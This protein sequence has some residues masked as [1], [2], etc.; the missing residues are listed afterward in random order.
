MFALHET[1]R[2]GLCRLGFFTLCVL[3]ACAIVTASTWVNSASRHA[4]LEREL[5]A[6]LG[7]SV[8]VARVQLTRPNAARYE[9]LEIVDPETRRMIARAASLQISRH[10]AMTVIIAV[11]PEVDAAQLDV[12][13]GL[14]SRELKLGKQGESVRW[15]A[16]KLTLQ[17]ADGGQRVLDDVR[18][19]FDF[20][21]T[22]AQ[23]AGIFRVASRRSDDEV[24]LR[25]VRHRDQT[26][27]NTEF[28][29]K[30]SQAMLPCA[31]VAPFWPAVNCL[32]AKCEFQGAL[33]AV[34]TPAG[35]NGGLVGVLHDVDLATLVAEHYPEQLEGKAQLVLDNVRFNSGRLEAASGSVTAGPGTIDRELATA[36][37]SELS[38]VGPHVRTTFGAQHPFSELALRFALD[39]GGLLIAGACTGQ[40]GSVLVDGFGKSINEPTPAARQPVSRLAELLAPSNTVLMPMSRASAAIV[41]LLPLPGEPSPQTAD[42]RGRRAS[43]SRPAH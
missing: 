43:P 25:V 13:Y 22:W 23:A 2:R 5:S 3:P 40:P 31:L 29:L 21:K 12:L 17:M 4:E 18:G 20:K 10:D 6:R 30:T 42:E 27:P 11:A 16:E 32:G 14:I 8:S 19:Q 41:N 34:E 38:L 33:G 37:V 35:W 36:L 39:S 7:L 26:P 1:T 24:A 28:E 9:G 15:G